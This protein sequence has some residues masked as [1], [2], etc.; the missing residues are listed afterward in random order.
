MKAMVLRWLFIVAFAFA[1][2][3][4]GFLWFR[5]CRNHPDPYSFREDFRH[6]F[7]TPHLKYSGHHTDGGHRRIVPIMLMLSGPF[8]LVVA[9]FRSAVE[10]GG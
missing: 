8:I 9:W 7:L 5:S 1:F 10:A 2:S 6:T 4:F 3:G